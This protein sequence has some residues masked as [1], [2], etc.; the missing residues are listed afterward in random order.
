MTRG[1]DRGRSP[2]PR[3]ILVTGAFG[4]VGQEVV[5]DLASRGDR[6]HAVDLANRRTRRAAARL[7]REHP[8]EWHRVDLT[9]AGA[10]ADL[11]RAI[12]PDVVVHLAALLPPFTEADPARTERIN[13]GATR[14]L[15]AACEAR[16]AR[17]RFVHASTYGIFGARNGDRPLPPIDAATPPSPTDTYGRTKLAAEEAVRASRLPWVVLRLGGVVPF[18][19]Q[20]F[21]PAIVRLLF[22]VPYRN[23]RHG[24]DPRDAGRAFGEATVRDVVGRVL[25][26]AGDDA[27]KLRHGE[28]SNRYLEAQ[29]L[30]PVPEE[31]FC[32]GHP[33]SD[34]PWF[35]EDHVDAREAERLLGFQR[36]KPDAYFAEVARRHRR[37]R[38]LLRPVRE[39]VRDAL[40]ALSPYHG[41]PRDRRIAP[42]EERLRAILRPA[43]DGA[44]TTVGGSVDV[45]G[46]VESVA[47]TLSEIS[48]WSRWSE[49][50]M[51][52]GSLDAAS[53]TLSIRAP[54]L[55]NFS[56]PVEVVAR[57]PATELRWRGGVPGLFVAEHAITL[58]PA[59]PGRVAIANRESF[60]GV[61]GRPVG[62]LIRPFL[63]VVYERDCARL[64]ACAR[65]RVPVRTRAASRTSPRRRPA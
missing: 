22:E 54:V 42:I 46:T 17:A 49:V 65:E 13:A 57:D 56:L 26:V 11:V 41:A 36:T 2:D 35:I 9:D 40:L 20:S 4:N 62:R 12:D 14:N 48:A 47:A 53:A 64:A 63:D 29:G 23:R 28:F 43:D 50:I 52:L 59:G 24:L 32:P 6:V 31:A 7:R 10:V 44:V 51:A 55:G 33:E 8:F 19:A 5:A 45:E 60:G 30:L 25:L 21:D 61:L 27:W 34:D 38:A 18:E 15:I 1:T 16:G 39:V 58:G 37:Q 3:R